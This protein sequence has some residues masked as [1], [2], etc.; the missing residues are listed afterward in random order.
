[1]KVF[2]A[3]AQI[4]AIFAFLTLGSLLIIV[5]LHILSLEDALLKVEEIYRDPWRS[6]QS[7]LIG[8]VFIIVGLTFT[9]ML[10]RKGRDTEA[11]IFQGEL[12]PIVVSLGAIEDVVKKILRR[13]HLI[14]EFKIKTLIRG[15][16]VEIKVR[17]VLWSGGH[18]AELLSEVQKEI[19]T[20]VSKLLG[21]ESKLDITC[22]IQ[23]IEDHENTLE[24]VARVDQPTRTA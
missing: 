2:N 11:L 23:K 15:K 10:I 14:K 21:G 7:G 8:L 6:L 1:M 18:V 9:K 5:S 24:D 19:R 16:D 17:L 4:F 20:R 22:D 12:G 3:F 13:F